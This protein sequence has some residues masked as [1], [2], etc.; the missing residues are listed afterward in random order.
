MNPFLKFFGGVLQVLKTPLK[1]WTQAQKLTAVITGLGVV[2]AGL[3]TTAV[4]LHVNEGNNLETV[5]PTIQTTVQTD[6]SKETTAPT[7]EATTEATTVPAESQPVIN[8]KVLELQKMLE[9][10]PETY[11]WIM[12]PN[13]RID[14]VVMFSPERPDFYLYSNYNGW[15]N[16]GGT[17]YI[18]EVCSVDPETQVLQ[19]YSHNML[20]GAHFG[21]LN[22]YA[23][24]EFW[25]ENPYIYFT[26]I[27][28]ARTF[29]VVTAGYMP[30]I[31]AAKEGQYRFSD[32]IT[33]STV[34]E[35]EE[36]IQHFLDSSV[37][38]T[39][40]VPEYLDNFIMLVTCHGDDERFI[41]LA[42]ETTWVE[43]EVIE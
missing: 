14:E 5:P 18:D 16:A 11:G 24:Q 28:E 15:F 22:Y 40:V 32:F 36:H 25:E 2:L 37:I 27:N 13:T 30:Y 19:I 31:K 10:N 20:S 4:V 35:F 26:T 23:K 29:E 38:E 39:G 33:Y 8:D 12:V 3:T 34:A 7:T 43:P 6:P 21:T 42:R 17:A 41:V 1:L 9:E